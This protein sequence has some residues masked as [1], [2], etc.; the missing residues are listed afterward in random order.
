MGQPFLGF[1][2]LL[3]DERPPERRL[4]PQLPPYAA[5]HVV[6]DP[7][8]LTVPSSTR[9]STSSIRRS[10]RLILFLPCSR[11][12]ERGDLPFDLGCRGIGHH[13]RRP[14]NAELHGDGLNIFFQ[15]IQ[16]LL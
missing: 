6:M 16:E 11:P 13:L 7:I 4:R 8:R 12:K 15:T 2:R 1:R 14:D 9:R 3:A 10:I 5:C